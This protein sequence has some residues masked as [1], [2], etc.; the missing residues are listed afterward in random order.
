M[1]N[2]TLD[3]KIYLND[4]QV[5]IDSANVPESKR[6]MQIVPKP[7][8]VVSA[9]DFSQTG[10]FSDIM[11]FSDTGE[12]GQPGN[13]VEILVYLAPGSITF[14]YLPDL[15]TVDGD[16]KIYEE[17]DYVSDRSY[18]DYFFSFNDIVSPTNST[19]VFTKVNLTSVLDHTAI[20]QTNSGIE[21]KPGEETTVGAVLLE[22]NSGYYFNE[23][24]IF[25][26]Y[27]KDEVEVSFNLINAEKNIDG[28][29]TKYIYSINYSAEK[30]TYDGDSI[31]ISLRNP[32]A[33]T[34]PTKVIEVSS[35]DFGSPLIDINGETKEFK[36]TGSIGADFDFQIANTS[37]TYNADYNVRIVSSDSMQSGYSSRIEYKSIATA[38]DNDYVEADSIVLNFDKETTNQQYEVRLDVNGDTVLNSSIPSTN[39]RYTL[40]QYVN[41]I[42]RF[43]ATDGSTNYIGKII[44]GRPDLTAED[45]SS[46]YD[47]EDLNF[48]VTTTVPNTTLLHQPYNEVFDFIGR[49]DP[50]FPRRIYFD[51][52]TLPSWVTVQNMVGVYED[53]VGSNARLISGITSTYIEIGSGFSTLTLFGEYMSFTVVETSFGNSVVD[54]F[55]GSE[56]RVFNESAVQSGSD[57]VY[58]FDV[59]IDK[60]PNQP[61]DYLT[62]INQT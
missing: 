18:V 33:L 54:M 15:G 40:N 46:V 35:L 9:S 47:F 21:V 53:V 56:V 51:T 36:F 14:D 58:T 34:I 4:I 57:I 13:K 12:A 41:P 60:F 22:A 2:Y 23:P 3:T 19:Q 29:T 11:A 6:R 37:I 5:P 32:E 20:N 31:T 45:L 27:K 25:Q 39:P 62:H 8:F 7:G 55:T 59:S 28:Y 42:L 10:T 38:T 1:A 43:G 26:S 61:V 50:S 30:D 52:S 16:A 24:I 44:T 48:T 49:V 17:N